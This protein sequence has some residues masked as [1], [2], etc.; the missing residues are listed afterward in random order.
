MSQLIR[1]WETGKAC[2]LL[3][4][5]EKDCADAVK[6]VP[7]QMQPKCPPEVEPEIT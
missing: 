5:V 7:C 6:S 4:E 3:A 2:D 1:A